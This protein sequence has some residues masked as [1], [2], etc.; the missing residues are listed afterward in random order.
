MPWGVLKG[1]AVNTTISQEGTK[2]SIGYN[3]LGAEGD[4][5]TYTTSYPRTKATVDVGYVAKVDWS[6]II[7]LPP[8]ISQP[9]R[10]TDPDQ[11]SEKVPGSG[12]RPERGGHGGVNW[13]VLG[14]SEGDPIR[15]IG[16]VFDP[17]A[18]IQACISAVSTPLSYKFGEGVGILRGPV[19]L[20]RPTSPWTAHTN[21]RHP[22][23]HL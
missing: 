3:F 13:G 5:E 19:P 1:K 12:Y 7:P 8:S 4:G 10:G 23:Q 20:G 18:M 11:G 15:S 22:F 16:S 17:E 9:K 6:E 21:S 2:K 14:Y